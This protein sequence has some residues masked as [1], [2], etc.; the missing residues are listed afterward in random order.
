MKEISAILEKINDLSHAAMGSSVLE[1][2]LLL[3]YTRQ[4]YDKL[5]S[6][7]KRMIVARDEDTP[8]IATAKAPGQV[9]QEDGGSTTA[10]A[11][12]SQPVVADA[13]LIDETQIP[14]TSEDPYDIG[15]AMA[16]QEEELTEALA[17]GEDT[18]PGVVPEQNIEVVTASG[19][20]QTSKGMDI[21]E[22]KLEQDLYLHQSN[23]SF[24][25]PHP[26]EEEP[27][28]PE[29]GIEEDKPETNTTPV[30][31]IPIPFAEEEPLTDYAQIFN[32]A[33]KTKEEGLGD[34]RKMI[35][36]NDKYLF[37]NELFNSQKKAYEDALDKLNTLGEYKEAVEWVKRG[38]AAQYK[39]SED[40][41]TVLDFYDVLAKHFSAR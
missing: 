13:N 17:E 40:D 10:E 32:Y 28:F 35:G 5:L 21:S 26:A 31:D 22:Q 36:I 12:T 9:K 41:E 20:P 16:E 37:L 1:L 18:E 6:E 8:T 27:Y 7:R 39:W 15:N 2:D 38:I 3:D 25:P 24:E 4:L 14:E 30:E 23:I 19:V 29:E 33:A 11:T 34:I